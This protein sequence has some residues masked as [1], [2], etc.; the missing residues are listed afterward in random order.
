MLDARQL[1]ALQRQ[2]ARNRKRSA[3]LAQ[4]V[5]AQARADRERLRE[6][7]R[8]GE[9]SDADLEGPL[10][11]LARSMRRPNATFEL[12][13]TTLH[14]WEEAAAKALSEGGGGLDQALARRLAA[15][16][17]AAPLPQN[18]RM[19]HAFFSDLDNLVGHFVA[20]L[21]R[22]RMH[23]HVGPLLSALDAWEKHR[24]PARR[25]QLPARRVAS[26]PRARSPHRNARLRA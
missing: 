8:V 11:A 6:S 24:A 25:S 9:W 14:E 16:V 17:T 1:Q 20:L 23:R 3:E 7:G 22:A 4:S 18:D 2:G 15:L 10:V 5:L 12:E 21:Q 26:L 19:R 13:P